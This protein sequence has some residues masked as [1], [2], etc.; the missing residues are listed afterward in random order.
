M[1]KISG[2]IYIITNI[3]TKKKYIG[4]AVNYLSNGK[5]WGSFKRWKKHVS[6]ALNNNSECRLLENS[7]LK[8]GENNFIVKDIIIC[9]IEN[10]NYYEDL[11]INM[12]NTLSPNGYNL[13]TG[14]GNGRIHSLETRNLMSKT[15][16]GK[17]HSESTK[18][19]IKDS[20]KGK[21]I[22]SK[23]KELTSKKSKYRNMS[24]DN[25]N[26]LSKALSILSLESLPM[27]IGLK[28]DNRHKNNIEIIFV[29]V[30]KKPLKQFGKKDMQLE[31][32]I[33]LAIQYKNSLT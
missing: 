20:N 11:F 13:M 22:S 32:K 30:P 2:V 17:T 27:Y 10:L 7:I 15:R 16:T 12:Y 5:I 18:Q 8:Y 6:N 1:D 29:R 19:K 14:G 24:E 23:T 26:I 31:E 4:Q 28:I 3:I 25:K 9:N 33:K 21:I